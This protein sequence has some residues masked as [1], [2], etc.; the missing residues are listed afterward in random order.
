MNKTTLKKKS[1]IIAKSVHL[2][3]T[4]YHD[5]TIDR[6]QK[7]L[8]ETILGA[9]IW[10][11]PN[12]KIL[13]SGKISERALESIRQDTKVKLVEEHGFP[14]KVAGNRLFNEHLEE[15]KSDFNNFE[16]LFID[17]FGKYNLVLKEEN[18]RLKK[19]QKVDNFIS[20]QESYKLAEI[21]L[22][23]PTADDYKLIQLKKYLV[24]DIEIS[25][26]ENVEDVDLE[27]EMISFFLC[28]DEDKNPSNLFERFMRFV[29]DNYSVTLNENINLLKYFKQEADD[30]K[31]GAAIKYKRVKEYKSW[32]F[33]NYASTQRKRQIMN[34]IALE[35]EINF[36]A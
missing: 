34:Y 6:L 15:V 2:L 12:G 28:S 10:Y 24:K 14:R 7:D 27:P 20:E 26:E 17:K 5:N 33:S 36:M 1:E 16:K 18:L 35:L 3:S 19:Y 23:S 21:K 9:A 25:D 4:L 11:M 29:I 8:L 32:H 13:F 31:F 22:V 30:P